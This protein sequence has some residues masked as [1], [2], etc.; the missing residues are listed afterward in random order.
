[1]KYFIS[2]LFLNETEEI[3]SIMFNCRRMNPV[4]SNK[5]MNIQQKGGALRPDD[6][7]ISFV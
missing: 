1:M 5:N 2:Q 4:Q 7:A 6:L 3:N